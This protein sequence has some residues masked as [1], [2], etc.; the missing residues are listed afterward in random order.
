MY[1]AAVFKNIEIQIHADENERELFPS[2]NETQNNNG[3]D[4][5]S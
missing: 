2:D 1:S 5:T 4:K 3:N